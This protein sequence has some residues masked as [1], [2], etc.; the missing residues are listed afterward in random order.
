MHDSNRIKNQFRIVQ[1]ELVTG[2]AAS[3]VMS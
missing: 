2:I 3:A 1:G